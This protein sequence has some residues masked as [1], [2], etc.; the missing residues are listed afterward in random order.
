MRFDSVLRFVCMTTLATV[1]VAGLLVSPAAA[2]RGISQAQIKAMQQKMQQQQQMQQ[3]LGK[4]QAQKDQETISK[5][6][7]NSNG[8]IDVNEKP[9]WDKYWREVRSGK[10][11]HPY[12]SI[13]AADVTKAA[14]PQSTKTAAKKK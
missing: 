12:D 5:Y 14:N 9:A 3:G 2:R 10:E 8:K 7:L 11:P 13:T 6:D 1:F 4:V